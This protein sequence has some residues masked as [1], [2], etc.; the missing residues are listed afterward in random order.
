MKYV[1][2]LNNN[3]K[4]F[5]NLFPLLKDNLDALPKL[6]ALNKTHYIVTNKL[7]IL[8]NFLNYLLSN[9]STINVNILFQ[10]L[11]KD[12]KKFDLLLNQI[13]K[14]DFNYFAQLLSISVFEKITKYNIKDL[15]LYV[16]SYSSFVSCN[17]KIQWGIGNNKNISI[18]ILNHYTKHVASSSDEGITWSNILDE[19]SKEL[20][21]N[22]KIKL[23]EMYAAKS[24]YLM[25]DVI[26]CY[27]KFYQNEN[28]KNQLL[29]TKEANATDHIWGVKMAI[30][31][32]KSSNP[33]SWVYDYKFSKTELTKEKRNCHN[34]LGRALMAI[35]SNL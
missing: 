12:I 34:L 9:P 13:N 4:Y 3:H 26:G 24:F 7:T 14:E 15:I 30:S 25:K 11:D 1:A 2:W 23:Y 35:R 8:L 17:V 16:K 5:Q 32:P 27:N 18:N 33:S 31:N 29:A 19:H 21:K 10:Y 20:T 28:I 6:Y 22:E